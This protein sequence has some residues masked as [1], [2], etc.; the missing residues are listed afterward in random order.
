M[1]GPHSVHSYEF[2]GERYESRVEMI[3]KPSDGNKQMKKRCTISLGPR[4]TSCQSS[5][6]FK[7]Q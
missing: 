5:N 7:D 4:K 2:E 1:V 6:I 3:R